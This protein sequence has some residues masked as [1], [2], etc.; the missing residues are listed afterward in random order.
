MRFIV[1][2]KVDA[3]MEA[4]APPNQKIID[5][6]GTLVQGSLKSGV[7]ENGAG[8]HPSRSRARIRRAAGKSAIEK[9]PYAG[10][11]ELIA[12]VAM[13][14]AR[15]MDAALTHASRF[16]ETLG[17][18]VALEVGPVVEP[19]DLGMMPKPAGK[20]PERF[21]FL[22]KGSASSERGEHPSA[23]AIAETLTDVLGDEGALLAVEA[24]APSSKGA[25]LPSAGPGA[26][27]AWVDGPF[28]ESKELIAGF[29]IL[30]L[31]TRED[32]L[33]WADRY[34]AIL[35]ENEVDVIE[36]RERA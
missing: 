17:S 27:R 8:L 26:K 20:I 10:D 11:N 7:F 29:S 30:S 22:C 6:M 25:R 18:D 4:G 35:G 5:D 15:S 34:A 13:I 23:R 31:A 33:A 19:W 3:K 32:A 1:M 36:L 2:H 12:S 14:S 16:V 28:A 24:L 9:G 21:L